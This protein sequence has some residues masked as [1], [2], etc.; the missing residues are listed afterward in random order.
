M[1]QFKLW[2]RC[3]WLKKISK[4]SQRCQ[5]GVVRVNIHLN[6]DEFPGRVFSVAQLFSETQ[7]D[8]ALRRLAAVWTEVV[9]LWWRGRGKYTDKYTGLLRWDQTTC[10]WKWGLN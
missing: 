8:A 1:S 7:S 2:Q 5:R 10:S 6:D 3:D 4:L 9:Q